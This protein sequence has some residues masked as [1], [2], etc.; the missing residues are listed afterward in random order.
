MSFRHDPICRHN[1]CLDD[2]LVASSFLKGS[3]RE[4]VW[5]PSHMISLFPLSATNPF[6][7]LSF[8]LDKH[9]LLVCYSPGVLV[10]FSGT[11]WH[12][13]GQISVADPAEETASRPPISPKVMPEEPKKNFSLSPLIHF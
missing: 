12:S 9:P 1:S 2:L 7:L 5:L 6:P 3:R 10:S 13:Q 11:N 8:D 4:L